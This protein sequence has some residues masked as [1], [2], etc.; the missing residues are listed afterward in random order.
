MPCSRARSMIL[1]LSASLV[2]G[3]KF[4]VPRHKRLTTSPVR[5]RWVYF[6]LSALFLSILFMPTEGY[7][8]SRMA[9]FHWQERHALSAAYPLLTTRLTAGR[10]DSYVAHKDCLDFSSL[11]KNCAA[12]I[13]LYVCTFQLMSASALL[14]FWTLAMLA[15]VFLEE[16]QQRL[17][18]SWQRA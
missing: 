15:Y 5:P 14:R 11:S 8:L 2:S 3:P 13:Y 1:K 18:V 16:E 4:I 9:P 10:R 17:R 7:E 12:L 6:T